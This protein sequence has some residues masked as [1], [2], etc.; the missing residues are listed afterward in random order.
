MGVWYLL[1]HNPY[2]SKNLLIIIFIC[3]AIVCFDGLYQYFVGHNLL[4]NPKYNS[5]RLTGLFGDEPI[6]GRY[7]AYLSIFAF[8]LLYSNFKFSKTIF[9]ISMIFIVTS[10]VTVFLTGERAAFFYLIFS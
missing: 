7:I 9:I 1:D 6:I 2:L 4:N 10:I 5:S 8:G 3:I